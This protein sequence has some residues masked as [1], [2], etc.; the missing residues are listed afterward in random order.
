MLA[1]ITHR[2]V[3]GYFL[4]WLFVAAGPAAAE[5]LIRPHDRLAIC[6]DGMTAGLGYSVY[7]EDYLLVSQRIEGIEISQF[8]WHAQTAKEFLAHLETDVASVQ[9]RP[10]S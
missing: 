2:L 10:S 7:I 9:A 8:G 4:L 3:S 5:P 1:R 6:G